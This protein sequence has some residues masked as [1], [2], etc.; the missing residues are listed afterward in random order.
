MRFLL[1]TLFAL[2]AQAQQPPA[3]LPRF[4]VVSVKPSNAPRASWSW[5]T[6]PGR[7]VMRNVTLQF[8]VTYAYHL[9]DYQLDGG[10]KWLDSARFDIDAKLP[11]GV[12]MSQAPAML[13]AML[14]D[15][16]Q[17]KAHRETRDVREYS[18]VVAQGGPRFVDLDKN[19]NAG[20]TSYTG[21]NEIL[22]RAKTA[23]E[24]AAMLIGPVGAPVID[25]TGLTG[26]Y[27]FHLKYAPLS[28]SA[29][30]DQGLPTIFG[31][32]LKLGLKLESTKGP[33]EVMVIDR[34]E[35]PSAN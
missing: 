4:E 6:P 26:K 13:Q 11:D 16:F 27:D 24:I 9:N 21:P 12:P 10:P 17:V 29:E 14:E 22:G 19:D 34:A 1:L 28:V 20:A 32:V 33:V 30:A 7:V 8:L 35:M 18:L 23:P 3:G 25:R 5:G 31:A 2:G 15:R